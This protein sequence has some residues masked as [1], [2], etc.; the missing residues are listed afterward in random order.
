[1]WFQIDTLKQKK[2]HTFNFYP[3]TLERNI[4]LNDNV[5][6]NAVIPSVFA[7]T[8]E[9]IECVPTSSQPNNLLFILETPVTYKTVSLAFDT[10]FCSL[11]LVFRSGGIIQNTYKIPIFHLI[12]NRQEHVACHMTRTFQNT[13]RKTRR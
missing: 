11:N 4:F 12:W 9:M 6:Y 10:V 3:I 5:R 7:W 1:M 13:T 2:I 8:N